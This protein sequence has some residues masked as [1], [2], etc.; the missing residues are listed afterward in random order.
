MRTKE[1]IVDVMLASVALT[2]TVMFVA[3]LVNIYYNQL[4]DTHIGADGKLHLI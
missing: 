1:E 3:V 4:P 2:I